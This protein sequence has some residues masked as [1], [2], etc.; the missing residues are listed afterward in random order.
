MHAVGIT[1]NPT[2][3]GEGRYFIKKKEK[4]GRGCFAGKSIGEKQAFNDGFSC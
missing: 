4:F 3:K 2:N 1:A